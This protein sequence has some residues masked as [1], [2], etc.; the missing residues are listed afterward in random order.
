MSGGYGKLYKGQVQYNNRE[1]KVAV[2]RFSLNRQ[3]KV[4][5]NGTSFSWENGFLKEFEV[6]FKYKHEN[7]VSLVG[8]CKEMDEKIIVYEYTSKKSLDRRLNDTSLSWS[9]RL[10]ICIDI[11]KGLK[12]LHG[13]GVGQDAVIH[14]DLKSSNILLTKDGKAKISGFEHALSYPTNEKIKYVIDDVVGSPG[15]C[16][17]L[18]W[19]T[20]TL[21][22]ESD[23]YS[24]GVIL[25][26]ILCGRLAYPQDFRDHNQF[27]DVLVKRLFQVAQFDEIVFD[28]LK[29]QIERKSLVTFRR[30]AFQCLHAE[31]KER[32]TAGEVVVQLQKALEFQVS[33]HSFRFRVSGKLVYYS[34]SGG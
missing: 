13:G 22:K 25:F 28:D 29:E 12:F 19:E 32:P 24:L 26:E 17:P 6:L 7:I 4:A 16:D 1:K 30:I 23:I 15:Y 21:T 9:K 3:K 10:K 18:Y 14:R 8:Y 5:V 20:H 27:L 31:I 2:K 34:A 11:A 33:F